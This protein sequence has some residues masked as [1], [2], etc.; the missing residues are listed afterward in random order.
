MGHNKSSLNFQEKSMKNSIPL[1]RGFTLIELLVV[2]AIIALLAAIL[3]PVFARARENARRTSCASNLKQIGIGIAQYTQDFDEKLPPIY[4]NPDAASSCYSNLVLPYIKSEQ[5]FNCPSTKLKWVPAV[6]SR[7]NCNVGYGMAYS[8]G[9]ATPRLGWAS[10]W[11]TA[12]HLS[13][14][15]R[16]SE[17]IHLG[18]SPGL[19][20]IWRVRLGGGGS[21]EAAYSPDDRHLETANFLFA[22]GHVK[23][24]KAGAVLGAANVDKFDYTLP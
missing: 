11:T 1:K 10:N 2:I 3:F 24:L 12:I 21:Q 15:N 8:G 20:G 6:A 9:S 18:D 4:W 13:S 17:I 16:P 7:A 19:N 23:A 5:I 22:D 14:V